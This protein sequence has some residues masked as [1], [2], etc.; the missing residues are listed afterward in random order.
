M[1]RRRTAPSPFARLLKPVGGSSP[2][3]RPGLL[4]TSPATDDTVA[5]TEGVA[6]AGIVATV[7]GVAVNV[8]EGFG[9]GVA[10]AVDEGT[11]VSVGD[12]MGGCLLAG[13]SLTK[14]A[15]I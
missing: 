14:G 12:G 8:G 9:A 11:T 1:A 5:P 4:P 10:L 13:P 15:E 3:V 2:G 7:V 6:F